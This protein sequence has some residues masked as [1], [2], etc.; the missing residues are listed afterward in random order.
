M[1]YYIFVIM[2]VFLCSLSQLLLKK[3]ANVEH[4]SRIH[5]ILNPLVIV[6]YTIFFGS[7]LIN[8]WAMSNGLQLKE[9]AMLESLGY[10]F[11]PLLSVIV[12]K[13]QMTRRTI[14]AVFVILSGIFIFYL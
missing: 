11:V 4:Q 8:I 5:E 6:A 7:L 3:S 13:E 10:V 14:L 9:M 2:G 12:L 1:I